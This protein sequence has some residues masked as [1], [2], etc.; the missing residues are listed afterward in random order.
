MNGKIWYLLIPG[1]IYLIAR[2]KKMSEMPE[3]WTAWAD[4]SDILVP[5]GGDADV[6]LQVLSHRKVILKYAWSYKIDPALISGIIH[7]ESEGISDALRAGSNDVYTGLMQLGFKTAKA[8]GYTG[9]AEGLLSPDS[10]VSFGTKYF[11]SQYDRY[12]KNLYDAISAYNAGHSLCSGV[13]CGNQRYVNDV[14]NVAKTYRLTYG[15]IWKY[16]WYFPSYLY[17]YIGL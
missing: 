12:G 13:V 11:K 15:F 3:E 2:S 9:S 16:Q 4:S 6:R 10:N 17:E 14:L 7:V 1:A 8:F 5:A